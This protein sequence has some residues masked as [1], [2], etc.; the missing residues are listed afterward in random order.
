MHFA[1]G[2]ISTLLPKL[3]ALLLEEYRLNKVVKQ[4]IRDLGD[5]LT[6]MQAA[7]VKLSDV[8][9]DQLDPQVKIWADDVRELSYAIEDSLDYYMVRLEPM[10]TAEQDDTF[11]A[12][13]KKTG[14]WFS[15]LKTRHK[16]SSNIKDIE[17]QVRKVKERYDRYKVEDVVSNIATTTTVVDPRLLALYSNVSDLVGIDKSIE[18]LIKRLY[19][20]DDVTGKKL[21]TVSVVGLGG[22]G[23]TTLAKAVYGELKNKFDCASFVQVGQKPSMEKVLKDILYEFDMQKYMNIS[24]SKLDVRQ[25]IDKVR[26]FLANKRYLIVIDDI[27]DIQTW[28]IIKCALVDSNTGTRIITT[29]RICEVAKRVCGVYNMKPLSEENSRKL[30]NARIFGGASISTDNQPAEASVKILRK[31]GGVPLAIIT[32]ASLLVNKRKDE[33]SK[34]YD[35]W[36]WG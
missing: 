35:Y 9:L 17:N 20:G 16:I 29:T 23:K 36:I 27:W 31:C 18:E 21:N 14:S 10:T 1:T 15:K 8:P 24:A 13:I 12:F 19:D 7:L 30:F 28:E 22:L 26:A 6:S 2:A 4:G 5:E 33:W 32:I 25:L 3:G 11:M 34:V